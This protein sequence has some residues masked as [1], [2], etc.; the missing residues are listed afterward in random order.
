MDGSKQDLEQR[1]IDHEVRVAWA[2]AALARARGARRARKER[3]V[4]LRE[5]LWAREQY[6]AMLRTAASEEEL[7]ALGLTDEM[8]RTA[9]LG[10]SLAAVWH[11]FRPPPPHD[12]P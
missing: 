10:S 9:Q 11:R 8:M 2:E 6:V 7:Q 12:R 4:A 5:E 3:R 1:L